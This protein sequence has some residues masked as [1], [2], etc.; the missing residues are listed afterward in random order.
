MSKAEEI[1][2]KFKKFNETN[3]E[4]AFDE[5][6]VELSDIVNS[7]DDDLKIKYMN[8]LKAFADK[9]RKDNKVKG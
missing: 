2:E 3:I 6:L 9:F 1:L 8:E 7:I 4:D 5:V